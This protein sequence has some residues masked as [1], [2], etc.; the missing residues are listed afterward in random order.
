MG[1]GTGLHRDCARR[2]GS[3]EMRNI[4]ASTSNQAKGI[5]QQLLLSRLN[6]EKDGAKERVRR[7]K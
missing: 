1:K 5:D 2:R 4:Q 3:E 6:K 7:T